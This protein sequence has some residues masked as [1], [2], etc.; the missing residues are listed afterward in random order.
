MVRKKME[1]NEQQ[2]RK[3]AREARERGNAPSEEGATTGASK[4]HQ[5][6]GG[7]EEYRDK[8]EQIREGKQ[9]VIQQNTPEPRPGYGDRDD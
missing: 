3:K 1:G 5:H 2:R 7:R 8:I 9:D 6:A 4:Q